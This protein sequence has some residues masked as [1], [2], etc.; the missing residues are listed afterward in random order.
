LKAPDSTPDL[1]V[2]SRLR[3][4]LDVTISFHRRENQRVT[5]YIIDCGKESLGDK[6]LIEALGANYEFIPRQ[7]A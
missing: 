4:A 2:P 1:E 7:S 5:I 6:R 3:I